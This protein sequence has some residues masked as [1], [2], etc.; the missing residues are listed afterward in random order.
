MAGAVSGTINALHLGVGFRGF[1]AYILAGIIVFVP[2]GILLAVFV[3]RAKES[4][5]GAAIGLV[6]GV[7]LIPYRPAIPVNETVNVCLLMGVLF[8]ATCW[9]IVRL[10]AFVL[11]RLLMPFSLL[12]D[13]ATNSEAS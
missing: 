11:R 8:G 7:L 1:I 13:G 12:V 10:M 4:L 5:W 9:P 3:N 6:V 2:V